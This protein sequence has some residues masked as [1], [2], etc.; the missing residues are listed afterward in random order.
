MRVEC[1]HPSVSQVSRSIL[2]MTGIYYGLRG[3]LSTILLHFHSETS[4]RNPY[5]FYSD[6][7][8]VGYIIGSAMLIMR[9]VFRSIG[10][11][12][13]RYF[14]YE[15]DVEFCVRTRRFGFNSILVINSVVYHKVGSSVENVHGLKEYYQ[16][17]NSYLR[18]NAIF[19]GTKGR[20][21]YGYFFITI[22]NPIYIRR[23]L[24][25]GAQKVLRKLFP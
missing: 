9:E 1:I 15:E 4:N 3:E 11:L 21:L 18:M 13:Y 2:I 25:D 7:I 17:R 10:L 5:H 20:Y 23:I 19:Q 16:T 12:D 24:K 6:L 22:I 8:K 14:A